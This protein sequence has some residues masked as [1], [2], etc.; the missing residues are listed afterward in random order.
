MSRPFFAFILC[1][2]MLAGFPV[3]ALVVQATLDSPK[4]SLSDS[5]VLSVSIDENIDSGEPDFSALKKD[6]EILR[7][8]TESSTRLWNG[9]AS[10]VTTWRITLRPLRAGTITI[11]PFTYDGVSSKPLTLTV[12]AESPDKSKAANQL[13]F[14]E[15]KTDKQD[16][17]V[18][19]QV[20]LTLNLYQRVATNDPSLS[21]PEG[22]GYIR[23]K[24]GA[25]RVYQTVIDGHEFQ[26]TE[27]RF[28]IFPQKSGDITLPAATF[29]AFIAV[30]GSAMFDPFLNTTG[31]QIGR[32]TQ[33]LTLHV[34]P[35]P[36]DFPADASWL[37]SPK[38]VMEDT[39]APDKTEFKVG[40]PI[41][42]T[43][44]L[45]A[46]G[47]APSVLPPLPPPSGEGYKVYPEKAKTAGAPVDDGYVSQRQESQAF[48]PTRPGQL[49]LPAVEVKY[50]NTR[51]QAIDVASLPARTLSIV[52][53]P[54]TAPMTPPTGG[55][56]APLSGD[57]AAP[58]SL[59]ALQ[60]ATTTAAP[61]G[62]L[63]LWQALFAAALA[64]WLVTASVWMRQHR[65][66]ARPAVDPAQEAAD[67]RLKDLRKA[68]AGACSQ[69]NPQA[70]RKAL[71]AWFT[72]LTGSK[73]VN[74]L[75]QLGHLA[76][77]ALLIRA[78]ADLDAALYSDKATGGWQGDA[79]RKAIADEE[80]QRRIKS[81]RS[82]EALANLYPG[83]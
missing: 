11:P 65:K 34:K 14:L 25:T 73:K 22:D 41:T 13:V 75:G 15:L 71:L 82:K 32:R 60:P 2:L 6:F 44:T 49:S 5:V 24:L 70:A 30:G 8:G 54:G 12:A 20:I 68:L 83:A 45:Q 35:K 23:E 53:A 62:T 21:W 76:M 55:V 56:T 46:H 7:S 47:I 78:C 63:I 42:R 31:K 61:T 40:E 1:V 67:V 72:A 50:W 28:A 77:S 81:G 19:E 36:A 48:I 17:W 16:V 57:S 18:Q 26:V 52:A 38:V 74:S 79:L 69:N 59:Q 66:A 80:S 58:P 39:L 29:S 27:N 9:Q 33:E 43:I 10:S 4:V 3:H 37:P 51:T 64:G